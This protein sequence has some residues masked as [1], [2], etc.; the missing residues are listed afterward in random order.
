[1]ISLH[2]RGPCGANARGGMTGKECRRTRDAAWNDRARQQQFHPQDRRR[3]LDL[4]V[5]RK[6]D[7]ARCRHFH[8]ADVVAEK[9]R[10]CEGSRSMDS[11][12]SA[13]VFFL[14][15]A[16]KCSHLGLFPPLQPF[17]DVD[18][19]EDH[20]VPRNL[21]CV[22]H[23]SVTIWWNETLQDTAGGSSFPRTEPS[24]FHSSSAASS[25]PL[26]TTTAAGGFP[27]KCAIT[28]QSFVRSTTEL[29]KLTDSIGHL[30]LGVRSAG[31]AGA[32][33]A[34]CRSVRAG[35]NFMVAS[36]STRNTALAAEPIGM[37]ASSSSRGV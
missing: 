23:K 24:F 25:V 4:C 12:C 1:M 36:A 17:G 19:G 37:N 9:F 8:V 13:P 6:P 14:R 26:S 3:A 34:A 27:S 2:Q 20:E 32:T 15:P 18:F 11:H 29:L 21:R 5:H 28:I 31:A 10:R 30:S 7:Q 16:G 35:S 22:E 33:A